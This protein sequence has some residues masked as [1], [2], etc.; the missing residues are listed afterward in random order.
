MSKHEEEMDGLEC[1]EGSVGRFYVKA[2][3]PVFRLNNPEE[4][5]S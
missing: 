1:P 2:N 5:V 4:D 3:E